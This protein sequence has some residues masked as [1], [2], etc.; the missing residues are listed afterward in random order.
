MT[1]RKNTNDLLQLIDEGILTHETV[2]RSALTW[3][4]DQEV[5]EMAHYEGFFLDDEDEDDE[6]HECMSCSST[7]TI[8]EYS[9]GYCN[10]CKYTDDKLSQKEINDIDTGCSSIEEEND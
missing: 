5:G 7:V 10:L 1:P 9:L 3:M 6:L 8:D 4:S 2:L